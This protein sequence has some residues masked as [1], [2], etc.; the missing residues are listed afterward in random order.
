MTVEVKLAAVMVL[1]R[2]AFE[3]TETYKSFLE[4]AG[5]T[6]FV[7]DN[8]PV[9]QELD[10]NNQLEYIHDAS[11]SG[12]SKAYNTAIEWAN[13]NNFSHLLLLDSDS[14][15]PENALDL[16]H[17]AI[18]QQPD[19]IILPEMRSSNHKISP[20]FFK[21]GK[22]FYGDAIQYGEVQLGKILA[23]NSGMILPLAELKENRFNENLPLDWSDIYFLRKVKKIKTVHIPLL[24]Q[25]GLSEHGEQ[26]IESAKFRFDTYTSGIK[27][28]AENFREKTMMIF[29]AKLKAVKL[30]KR[31]KT[32]WFFKH[33]LKKAL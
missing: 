29:W 13:K 16:Y 2:Q 25:H 3:E 20:F 32:I 14:G 1:Y 11:N 27:E 28:V 12:V 30:S 24:V 5:L 7:Y 8:S 10:L 18:K 17:K 33:F 4:S 31:Y 26:S 21:W 19:K 9:S 6:C 15:F 23:I 22:S